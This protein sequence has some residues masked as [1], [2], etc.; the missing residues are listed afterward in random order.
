[1]CLWKTKKKEVN[2]MNEK[3]IEI[4]QKP[5][6]F[7]KYKSG[8]DRGLPSINTLV[9]HHTDGEGTFDTLENWM[10]TGERANLYYQGIGLF[11]YCNDKEGKVY[12]IMPIEKWVYH[13]ESGVMDQYTIGIENIHRTG[14][15]TQAQYE[16]LAE[17]VVYLKNTYKN[18]KYITTHDWM[19]NTYSGLGSKGCPS[20][21]F[22]MDTLKNIIEKNGLKVK[23]INGG[24]EVA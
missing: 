9:I 17:L 20:S 2:T 16:S 10:L 23:V 21:F 19:R 4:I 11:H 3:Q 5:S 15:F 7:E 12:Q 8:F 1:M 18:F 24:L 6:I 14:E 22:K 13:S